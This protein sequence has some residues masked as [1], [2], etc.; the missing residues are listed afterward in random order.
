MKR[1]MDLIKFLLSALELVNPDTP[2]T[3]S[4]DD[5]PTLVRPTESELNEHCRLL[6]ERGLAHG[7]PTLSGWTLTGL[8][9]GGHDFLDDSRDSKV[10]QAARK[11]AGNLSF[12][13]FTKVLVRE[14]RW[15]TIGSWLR[16]RISWCGGQRADAEHCQPWLRAETA[17]RYAISKIETV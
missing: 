10:W 4:P 1:N 5:I 14:P 3:F 2:R 8:T 6:V 13:V 9:W 15:A 7:Q 12:G 16:S 17:T 11:A